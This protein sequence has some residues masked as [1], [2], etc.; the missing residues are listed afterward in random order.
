MI[1]YRDILDVRRRNDRVALSDLSIRLAAKRV[2]ASEATTCGIVRVKQI[3]G[4]WETVRQVLRSAG[5][6]HLC[7]R[8]RF[9]REDATEPFEEVVALVPGLDAAWAARLVCHGATV[10]LADAVDREGLVT[11][12]LRLHPGQQTASFDLPPSSFLEAQAEM[13]MTKNQREIW[14]RM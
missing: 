4:T 8:I 11:A 7:L 3:P 6:G 2:R 10:V 13:A 5:F 1:T 9:E 12:I 14:G